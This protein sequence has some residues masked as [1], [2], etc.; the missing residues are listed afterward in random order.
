[1]QQYTNQFNVVHGKFPPM[2]SQRRVPNFVKN[3]P[4]EHNI[5]SIHDI[6]EVSSELLSDEEPHDPR[7]QISSVYNPTRDIDNYPSSDSYDS[8]DSMTSS[9]SHLRPIIS[10]FVTP[11]ELTN[12]QELEMRCLMTHPP[13]TRA[14]LQF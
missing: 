9:S 1:M 12:Q 2:T 14:M 3:P 4:T 5:N 10:S 13:K 6:Q 8:N 11:S 7:H